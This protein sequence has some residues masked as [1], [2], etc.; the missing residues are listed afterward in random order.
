MSIK[1]WPPQDEVFWYLNRP[2]VKPCI[3][4]MHAEI[5]IIGGGMAGLSAAHAC[6]KKGKQVVLLEQYY[7]GSGA[8]GK[9]SGFITPN[10]ELS[11]TDFSKLF[12]LEAA[13][14]IWDIITDGVITIENN[15]KT[16]N[17]SCDYIPQNTLIIA[18]TKK[19]LEELAVEHSHLAKFNY[20]SKL[21]DQT[22][23]QTKIG[24]KKFFGGV[25]YEGT[26]GINAYQYCQEMKNFLQ[27]NYNVAIF[28]ETPVTAINSH[29]LTTPHATITADYI[30]VCTDR[31]L[32]QLGL[33]TQQVYNAQ[34]FLM[35]SQVLNNRQIKA[36]FPDESLM[37]WDS[38][39]F[40]NYFRLT[41]DKRLLLGGS[42]WSTIYTSKAY[43]DYM[44]M[45]RKLTSFFNESFPDAHVQFEQVWPG[46]VGVSK[47][48]A[49]LAGRD[50][51]QPHIYY[52]SAAA[53]LPVAAGLGNYC[54]QH[55][56]DGRTDLDAYFSPYRTFPVGNLTQ[57]LLGKTVSFALS[58]YLT[59][60]RGESN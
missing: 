16:N 45:V 56:I 54:A 44:P 21:Y 28:E 17:L 24:S 10:A 7:C 34:T 15:I 20:K 29:T 47:D 32:P 58:N 49:P 13:H 51:D 48:I 46:L 35:I 39:L 52:I 60:L 18:N 9:S 26:F 37:V 50:K 40:Y 38:G 6:A 4:T 23:I 31:F 36:I 2:A 30:V 25:S 41:G 57:V 59:K 14:K 53:G 42:S 22:S 19:D 8:S 11:L 1:L 27:N 33:L 55:L 43:H 12:N 3:N 5:A